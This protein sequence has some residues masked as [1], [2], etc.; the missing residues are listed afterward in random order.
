MNLLE[1]MLKSQYPTI[2]NSFMNIK[3]MIKVRDQKYNIESSK[4]YLDTRKELKVQRSTGNLKLR[5]L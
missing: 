4:S 5:H 2:Y 3:I 1:I